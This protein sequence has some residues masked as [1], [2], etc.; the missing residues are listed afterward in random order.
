MILIGLELL[1]SP[2]IYAMDLAFGALRSVTGSAGWSIAL[3]SMATTLLTQPL[4]AW[5]QVVEKRVSLRKLK[6][7]E[8]IA[9][10]TVGLKGEPKFRAVERIYEAHGYHPIQ[11]VALGAPLFVMLPFLLSALFLFSSNPSLENVPFLF[12]A[13]LSQ[14]DGLF[15]GLNILPAVMTGIT[16]MDSRI[17]FGTDRSAFRRFL[18]IALVM[19]VLVYTFASGIVLYWTVSNLVAMLTYLIRRSHS[20]KW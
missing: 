9:A 20:A 1:L 6:V 13:D 16:L 3:L 11:G 15:A 18:F 7:E 5:A 12:I 4:R 17:R 10:T 19:L 8:E 2:L 14:P